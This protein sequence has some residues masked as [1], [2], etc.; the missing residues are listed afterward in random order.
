MITQAKFLGQNA[1]APSLNDALVQLAAIQMYRRMG[2][3]RDGTPY[4]PNYFKR[5]KSD[6]V[7][8]L[9]N[10]NGKVITRLWRPM[11]CVICGE[12][13]PPNTTG[14]HVIPRSQGGKEGV[15]NRVPLCKTCNYGT[16]G[17][18]VSD[19]FEWLYKC[20]YDFSQINLDLM[21]VYARLRY[22]HA[23][24]DE[25][26]EDAPE[27]II[28]AINGICGTLTRDCTNA[29][30]KLSQSSQMIIYDVVDA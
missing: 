20:D 21:I 18:H 23:T 1:E 30:R 4:H 3:G 22:Q 6:F 25:L 11:T 27:Y 9:K 2:P 26:Q 13:L 16:G 19:L 12:S 17:K 29:G 14:D 8:A 10:P 7:Q 5:H 15:E 28:E 24:E